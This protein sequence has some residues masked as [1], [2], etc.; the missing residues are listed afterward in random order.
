MIQMIHKIKRFVIVGLIGSTMLIPGLLAP[1]V[2]GVASAD[3]QDELCQGVDAAADTSNC[4]NGT[5]DTN[6]TN[7]VEDLA[8]KITSIFSVIVGAVSIIMIIYAGFRY[9]TSGGE[10]GKVGS[11]KTTLIYALVGLVIV[12]LAQL[13]VRFVLTQATNATN[14]I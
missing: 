9:I 2:S 14:G 13:I 11:A 6:G 8:K 12:A 5:T 10:S 1:V 4:D 7:V 3:I